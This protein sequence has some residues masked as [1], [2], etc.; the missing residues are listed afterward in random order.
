[1]VFGPWFLR[2]VLCT[3]SFD[4]LSTAS[5]H[6]VIPVAEIKEQS[7]KYKVQSTVLIN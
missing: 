6:I 5:C 2:F 3:L 1:L 7:T 4:L